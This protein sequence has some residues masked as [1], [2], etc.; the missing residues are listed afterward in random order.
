MEIEIKLPS[1]LS[2]LHERSHKACLRSRDSGEEAASCLVAVLCCLPFCH[3]KAKKEKKKQK[4]LLSMQ[5]STLGTITVRVVM[6][7]VVE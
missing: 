1:V 4:T 7:I 6:L 3:L 5:A 2:S